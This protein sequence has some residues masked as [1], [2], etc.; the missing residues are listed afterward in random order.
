MALFSTRLS[1]HSKMFRSWA[2]LSQMSFCLPACL[3]V[4]LSVYTPKHYRAV[5]NHRLATHHPSFFCFHLPHP[6]L[7]GVNQYDFATNT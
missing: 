6:K 7:C 5:F 4:R 2:A 1:E 3:S